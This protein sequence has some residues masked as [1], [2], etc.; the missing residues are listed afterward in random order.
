MH[1]SRQNGKL[2]QALQW[3][4]YQ[5]QFSSL[6]AATTLCNGHHID[7]AK[8]TI[9]VYWCYT[10]L[11]QHDQQKYHTNNC[12]LLLRMQSA[13]CF[14]L[15]FISMFCELNHTFCKAT[16]KIRLTNYCQ[17][18]LYFRLNIQN[19]F[20][21]GTEQPTLWGNINISG[22]VGMLGVL[23]I[24]QIINHMQARVVTTKN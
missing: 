16:I 20:W 19:Y 7:Y 1:T 8:V 6:P 2:W 5:G 17:S 15:Y 13:V 24:F 12:L 11:F 18:R 23:H 4:S 22:S 14:C 21:S 3:K 9:Y 10:I